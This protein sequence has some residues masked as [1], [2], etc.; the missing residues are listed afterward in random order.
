MYNVLLEEYAF[1]P[2]ITCQFLL[3]FIILAGHDPEHDYGTIFAWEKL[4]G[5]HRLILIKIL[6]PDA[7]MTSIRQFVEEHI[8]HNFISS[9]SFDLKEIY[10]DST[11]KTPLIFIL[12]PG[13]DTH[14]TYPINS[15]KLHSAH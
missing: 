3:N 5:F 1:H 13:T 8:G 4:S 15:V 10:D 9:G 14:I 2:F 6:R 11:A 7:L 12:S